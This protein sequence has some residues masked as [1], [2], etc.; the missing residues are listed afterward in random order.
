MWNNV[1][2]S[3][4]IIKN[5]SKFLLGFGIIF[6]E[7]LG[8]GE[9]KN[10]QSEGIKCWIKEKYAVCFLS[11]I[12]IYIPSVFGYCYFSETKNRD[13][14]DPKPWILQNDFYLTLSFFVVDLHYCFFYLYRL[15]LWIQLVLGD[16]LLTDN[17]RRLSRTRL[18]F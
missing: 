4:N 17:F 9:K 15:Y 14:N 11:C 8:T 3:V 18:E 6:I 10:Y 12:Y 5:F 13:R 1:I 7:F 2:F 16:H